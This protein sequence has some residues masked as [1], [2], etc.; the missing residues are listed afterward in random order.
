MADRVDH[1]RLAAEQGEVLARDPLR[2]P[3]RRDHRQN[4]A[5]DESFGH[6]VPSG[7]STRGPRTSSRTASRRKRGTTRE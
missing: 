6:Q 5:R 2:A 7:G 3:A 4:L 1:Q